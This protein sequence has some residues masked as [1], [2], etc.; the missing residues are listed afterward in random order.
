[1]ITFYI[2]L[3]LAAAGLHV[4]DAIPLDVND[5]SS[6]SNASSTLAYGLMSYYSNNQ[7]DT[8]ATAIGTFSPPL[9]VWD[10]WEAGGVWGGM[11]DY[12][13]YTNDTSYN[14]T[15][16]QALLAQVGP[17]NNYLPPAYDGSLGND[18]QA[19]WAI[20][21]LSAAEYQFAPPPGNSSVTWLG[22]AEAVFNTMVPRWDTATCSGGLRWQIFK[23]N[24]GWDYKNS[25]SNGGFFQISARLARYTGN[26]TY[27]D[28]CEKIWDWMEGVHLINGN[29][30]VFDGTTPS[31]N[32]SEVNHVV[33]TY[34]PSML[35]YGTAMLYNYTNG[36]EV[37][38]TRTSGLLT[39]CANT[40]FSP[41]QNSTDVMYEFACETHGTCDSDQYSFKAYLARWMAKSAIVAPYL[42][43]A[44]TQLLTVTAQAAAQSCS[45]GDSGEMCGEK[46]YVGGHDGNSGVGQQLSALE[47]V[48]ALLL[49]DGNEYAAQRYPA[50][51]SNVRIEVEVPSN[52]FT[53]PPSPSSTGGSAKSSSAAEKRS[54]VP[55]NG[56]RAKVDSSVWLMLAVT[57]AFG[58]VFGGALVR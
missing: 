22:L 28:W 2:V 33:W 11:I 20:A 48:Q 25:I 53:V 6:I 30:D 7:S 10:W 40:F 52:T 8:A 47:V 5:T 58:T 9:E 4:V 38:Q 34:N 12:W 56:S 51:Q 27:V 14:P 44:V 17:D 43:D 13:A 3:A 36:S 45:G 1:M 26:Q 29:Y 39:A 31:Q 50:T 32:C 24:A 49:L 16:T 42:A 23:A 19:F 21:A 41:Y 57:F 37:W 15:V 35:L 55:N 18:D 54:A 46:W